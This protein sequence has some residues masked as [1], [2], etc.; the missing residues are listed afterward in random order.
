LQN[1]SSRECCNDIVVLLEVRGDASLRDCSV[2]LTMVAVVVV[3]IWG[4][5]LPLWGIWWSSQRG[6][7]YGV[8]GSF[9]MVL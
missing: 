3:E 7:W 4:K 5:I 6:E 2:G 1:I 8:A 9:S